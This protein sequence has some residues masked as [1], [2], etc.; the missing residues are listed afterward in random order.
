MSVPDLVIRIKNGYMS[1]KESINMPYSKLAEAIL[2]KLKQLKY[3]ED[4]TI[5]G[6]IVKN[7]T[8]KLRYEDGV[9]VFTDVQIFSTSG[10]R[11]YTDYKELKP[12]LGGMGTAIITTSK[13]IL[14]GKE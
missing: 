1:Q 4:F 10:R 9:S 2:T 11:W 7:M 13:G 8:V 12:V 5:D 3:I 14:T 6:D